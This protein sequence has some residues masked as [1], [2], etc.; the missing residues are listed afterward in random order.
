MTNKKFLKIPVSDWLLALPVLLFC[1][2]YFVF[3][4][5]D[6]LTTR[7]IVN[8]D[9]AQ[10][11]AWMHRWSDHQ[12]SPGDPLNE[13]AEVIQPW[14]FWALG[15]V[16]SL[17][18]DP[19]ALSKYLPFFTLLAA[20]LFCFF[21]VKKRFGTFVGFSA[22]V[23]LA[24]AVFE[25]MVGFNARAFAFPLLLAFAFFWLEKRTAAIAIT[26]ILS[27]LF[28]PVALLL[29]FVIIG[30]AVTVELISQMRSGLRSFHFEKKKTAWIAGAM[31]VSVGIAFAK[32]HQIESH[33]SIGPSFSKTELM[34]MEEFGKAGRVNFEWENKSLT[35]VL[36]DD[37]QD[38]PYGFVVM[39][40][41]I[42]LLIAESFTNRE[43]RDFDLVI[44]SIL[45]AGILLHLAAKVFLLKLFLPLRYF[46]YTYP[47]FFTLAFARLLGVRHSFWRRWLPGTSLVAGL[48]FT[49]F[50]YYAKAG[51]GLVNFTPYARLYEKI[52]QLP[53][54]GIIAGPP[55]M[56][57]Q[58]PLFCGRSVLFSNE[59]CHALYFKNYWSLLKPRLTDFIVAYTSPDV[60]VVKSFIQKY[61][62]EYLLLDREFFEGKETIY[63]FQ[64]LAGYFQSKM[65]E[66][67]G[68]RFALRQLPEEFLIPVDENFSILD[69][70]KL[71]E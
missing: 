21:L 31:L 58:V 36:M 9:A 1:L 55:A 52:E 49:V 43:H 53:G 44:F 34:A 18:L 41:L 56:C 22:A 38:R 54:N 39:L 28:Y 69:C 45:F 47:V 67:S 32:S 71:L 59:A 11:I 23:L 13:V 5:W 7:Y 17:F 29:E 15:R 42:G 14:G 35:A 20:S 2:V 19:V 26:L 8:D 12:F 61:Q 6:A 10:H 3:F 24:G 46:T 48:I 37:F 27:A 30:L 57:D 60:E 66:N 64:P 40:L 62:V 50:F 65:R 16:F 70:K 51:N 4:E 33:P 25:R 63:F 68:R